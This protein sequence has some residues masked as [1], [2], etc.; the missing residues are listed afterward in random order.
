MTVCLHYRI[1]KISSQIIEFII[2]A[3]HKLYNTIY[4]MVGYPTN[5]LLVLLQN[6]I[7]Q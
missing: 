3:P 7:S 1:S 2:F 4:S 6:V 5:N